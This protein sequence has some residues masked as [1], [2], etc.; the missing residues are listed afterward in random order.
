[1]KKLICLICL[2]AGI[3]IV[4]IGAGAKMISDTY[5]EVSLIQSDYNEPTAL[6]SD[7]LKNAP[8]YIAEESSEE[9]TIILKEEKRRV[10]VSVAGDCTLGYGIQQSVWNRFDTVFEKN[11]Y[12]YFLEN[13]K[14]I[15]EGDDLTIVNLEGP[16]TRSGTPV[17]KEFVF[18][19]DP[20]YVK[21]LTSSSVEVVN[22]ANNH[23]KDYGEAGYRETKE[24]LQAAGVGFFGEETV[25]YE[26]IKDMRIGII[27]MKGWSSD[28]WVKDSLKR[29][30]EEAKVQA[31]LIIVMF[32]WGV[33]GSN[34]PVQIQKD[35]AK[36]AIDEGV[37]LVV[38]SHPH[39][40]QGIETYQNRN[41]VY[42]LGNFCFGGNRNPSDKDTFIYQE[43]FEL[44]DLGILSVETQVIPCSISS[45]KDH[46]DYRPTPLIGEEK[47]R[48]QGRIETY[49]RL[50]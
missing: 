39:V 45:V 47:E 30:I 2:L 42:S 1:M 11:G 29:L 4:L 44:T 38:G 13:V 3:L 8:S 22:L 49:S 18:R 9:E 40:I 15:F 31:D 32:H 16:L 34:Y 23:T 17:E 33:E 21:I 26:T 12:N 14:A 19:G 50:Q 5:A 28:K 24:V 35:L 27:G 48:V 20:E 7:Q 36:Y 43:T 41:I 46:N 10:T 37:H 25:F 6:I